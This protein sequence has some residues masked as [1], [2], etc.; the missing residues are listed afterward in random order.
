MLSRGKAGPKER[1]GPELP[2]DLLTPAS[3]NYNS[4]K[5]LKNPAITQ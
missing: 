3:R 1:I 2:H 4:L 5:F